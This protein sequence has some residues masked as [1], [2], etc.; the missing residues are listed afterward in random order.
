MPAQAPACAGHD[1][2]I[3]RGSGDWSLTKTASRC[4]G[5]VCGGHR[6]VAMCRPLASRTF[7]RCSG[8]EG[9]CSVGARAIGPSCRGDAT[10]RCLYAAQGLSPGRAR[11]WFGMGQARRRGLVVGLAE[12]HSD[13]DAA[14]PH[15][16]YRDRPHIAAEPGL[17]FTSCSTHRSHACSG[18]WAVLPAPESSRVG[19]ERQQLG[20]MFGR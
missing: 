10:G 19:Q 20:H 13:R 4:R 11:S 3:C 15:L 17:V 6:P 1:R 12:P 9:R 5:A 2:G 8:H 14:L 18:L 7:G 16:V